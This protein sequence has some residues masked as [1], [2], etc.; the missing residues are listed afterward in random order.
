MADVIIN[1]KCILLFD[2]FYNYT[3]FENHEF[4]AFLE[5]VNLYFVKYKIIGKNVNHQQV[6]IQII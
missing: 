1:N 2:E 4:L 5:F 3:G 6:L